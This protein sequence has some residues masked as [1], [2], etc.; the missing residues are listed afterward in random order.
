MTKKHTHT[1]KDTAEKNKKNIVSKLK[2]KLTNLKKTKL[3]KKNQTNTHTHTKNQNSEEDNSETV[4]V[5]YKPALNASI[6]F[7]K[8]YG[9]V[10]LILIPMFFAIFFRMY[11]AY[12]PITDQW[13]TDT[14]ENYYKQQIAGQIN[15]QYPHLPDANKQSLI[16]AEWTKFSSQN[17]ELLFDQIST[18][19]ADFKSHFQDDTG[20][21]YLLAIDPYL[22]YGFGK[23]QLECG[24]SGCDLREDNN[25]Y[26]Y[27]NGRKGIANESNFVTTLGLLIHKISKIFGNNSLLFA[28]FL[29]PV[30]MISLSIIPAFFI[31]KKLGGNIGGFFAGLIVA[32][33]AALL[34]RTPGGFSDTDSANILMPLLIMWFFLEAFYSQNWKK[35]TGYSI[36]GGISFYIYVNMWSVSHIF[37]FILVGTILYF[38]VV[39]LT[40]IWKKRDLPNSLITTWNETKINLA[41]SGLFLGISLICLVIAKSWSIIPKLFEDIIRFIMIKDV[42]IS[43]VWPNV[44]TTVA[45]F[46]T[47]PLSQIIAQMG[48][49][50]LF[51]IAI[52]GLILAAFVKDLKDKYYIMYS[53]LLIIWFLGTAYSFTKGIRFAILMVP[54]FAV[55]T[56][57]GLGLIYKYGSEIISKGIHLNKKIT[58]ILILSVFMLIMIPQFQA[59]HNVATHEVP[60]YN[61]AWDKALNNIKTDAEDGIGYI[62]TW[63][64]FGH[65]FVAKGIRVTFDGGNQ[66]ERIHWV[67]KSLLTNDENLSAGILRMLNCGQEDAPHVIEKYVS[68]DT[69]KAIKILNEIMTVEKTEAQQKLE[70]YGFSQAQ[71]IEVLKTT[72]CENLLPQY[73]I[74]SEDMVGKSG[75]WGHFGSWDF[76]RAEMWQ[77]VRNLEYTPAIELMTTKYEL[78]SITADKYYFEIKK[79]DGDQWIAPWPRYIGTGG[80][81]VQNA[82]ASCVANVGG[83]QIPV[84]INLKTFDAKIPTNNEKN[85]KPNSIVYVFEDDV[86]N[87]EFSTNNHI[88]LAGF[89]VILRQFSDGYSIVLSDPEQAHSIFTRLFFFNGHGLTKIKPFD[90]QKQFSAGDIK[91]YKLDWNSEEKVIIY[92]TP[93]ASEIIVTEINGTMEP[94]QELNENTSNNNLIQKNQTNLTAE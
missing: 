22:W 60:S 32:I 9:F 13:A 61:D 62:T 72:H 46:N 29:I 73:V 1:K 55:A 59:A 21:T 40:H 79:T 24:N 3:D 87:K 16:N 58:Q 49:T 5:N 83:Q 78:D 35:T 71:I 19:S 84:E 64:D 30:V 36:L 17:K 10:L 37:D 6:N 48:G 89:S 69:V 65:W 41:K 92:E 33:N 28:F 86:L 91:T 11:P 12:L 56:G 23:N 67:G 34:S 18:T 45:E 25:Y 20:Q 70:Q 31:G 15:S 7:F 38:G 63:W 52:I 94:V 39:L 75:V 26:S 43:T 14:V 4:N 85:I 74:A 2:H 76:K 82:I 88:E 81:N 77:T 8:K 54:A 47:V 93:A 44:M 50:I 57:V 27:R 42:A 51:T 68:G 66:G 80:C 53:A 90:Y